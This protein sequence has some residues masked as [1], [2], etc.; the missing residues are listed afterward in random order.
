MQKEEE[1]LVPIIVRIPKYKKD[2]LEK[3]AT[4]QERYEADIIRSGIDKELNIQMYKDSLDFIVKELDRMLDEKLKPFIASQ[5]KINAKY[6]RTTVINTYLQGEI[7]Y[8]LLG[9]DMH[10]KFI[11]MLSDA[12][13]KANYYISRDTEDMSKKDLYDFYT[14]G[15]PY[16]NE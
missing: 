16:R 11:K 15:E 3:L 6:L 10:E 5:R 13:K 2:M 14:I 4:K 1:K 9:D 8:Q 7:M 12:R